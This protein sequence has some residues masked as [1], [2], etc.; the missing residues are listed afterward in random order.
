MTLLQLRQV[1]RAIIPGCKS[2][3]VSDTLLDIILNAGTKDIT[4]YCECLPTNKKF[5]AV[6]SQGTAILPY[7]LSS[8]I[9]NYLCIGGGGLWW[10]EG[11]NTT[12]NWKK[13]EPR[14]IEWLD[15]NRPNWHEISDGSP[16]DYA[17]DGDNLYV[18]PAPS[19][20]LT[21]GFWM[22]YTKMPSEMTS[23]SAYPFSGTT[24]EYTHLTPFDFAII[25]YAR[26]K[27]LPMLGKEFAQDEFNRNQNLYIK[28]RAEK[29][30]LYRRRPDIA[31]TAI[32]QG[33]AVR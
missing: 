21:N 11:D 8:V 5:N 12:P 10:N 1:A 25:Y 27:I 16:E 22:F 31:Q 15:E 30:S 2:D 4:A 28:E 24:T 29:L 13:L 17:I 19:A 33:P 3:V 18:V 14:T 7:A 32:F 26:W 20:A 23:T 9:A 6:A